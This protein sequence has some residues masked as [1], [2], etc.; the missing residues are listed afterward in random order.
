MN[1]IKK[2][3]KFSGKK[4]SYKSVHYISAVCTMF[5]IAEAIEQS[6]KDNFSGEGIKRAMYKE[7][8]IPENLDGVCLPST[9][10]KT[11]IEDLWRYRFI[12]LK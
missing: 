2:V 4:N 1:L 3:S 12:E 9:W 6:A 8:W 5:Y 7:K 11:I 10:K